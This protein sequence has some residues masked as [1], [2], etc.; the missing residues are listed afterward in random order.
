MQKSCGEC[1]GPA[2]GG[3]G[4]YGL[5]DRQ[6][7]RQGQHEQLLEASEETAQR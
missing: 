1:E 3:G 4:G 5:K 7:S 6:A 2:A